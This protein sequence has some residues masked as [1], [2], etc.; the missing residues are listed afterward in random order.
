MF[1]AKSHDTKRD[2]N[3]LVGARDLNGVGTSEVR[4]PPQMFSAAKG[5]GAIAP[6]TSCQ[7][8]RE[9]ERESGTGGAKMHPL[10]SLVPELLE[11]PTNVPRLQQIK[12][13]AMYNIP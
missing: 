4:K 10:H 2:V 5:R 3:Q 8:E 13:E 1:D 6:R 9:R 11:Q 7:R 12:I